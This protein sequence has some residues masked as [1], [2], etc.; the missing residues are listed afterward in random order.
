MWRACLFT[1]SVVLAS[2]ESLPEYK[3]EKVLGSLEYASAVAWSKD[4]YLL[5]ADLPA[6][7]V[8][9]IDGK[10]P[11]VVRKDLHASG[12]ALDSDGRLYA[13]EPREKRVTRTDKRGKTELLAERF[14]GKRLNGPNSIIVSK[15]G[16]VWFSDSAFGTA[17]K[18]K[19]LSFSGIYHISS[20][21]EISVIA[22]MSSRPNGLALSPDGR[23]LYAADSDARAIVAWDIEKSGAATNQRTLVRVKSG[24]PNGIV[25]GPDGKL[26]VACR[27]VEVFS[28]AGEPLGQIEMAE[29]PADLTFGDNSPDTLYIAART[30]VYRVRFQL[31]GGKPPAEDPARIQKQEQ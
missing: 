2:A 4:G 12:M 18:Q 30:S 25:A 28:A 10:G 9:K 11:S 16:H 13:C 6:G 31:T 20:K 24:I 27:T 21:G 23:V 19:E 3:V 22:R 8:T 15:N 1:I 29:K 5:I 17:D 14:E 26:Y 7:T